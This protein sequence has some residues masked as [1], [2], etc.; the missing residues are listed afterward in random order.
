ML[1]CW[2]KILILTFLARS[3][4]HPRRGPL[5]SF[6]IL[7]LERCHAA[8]HSA[9]SCIAR[10]PLISHGAQSSCPPAKIVFEYCVDLLQPFPLA[11]STG[12]RICT[13]VRHHGRPVS[14][15]QNR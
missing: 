10:S 13:E 6:L 15:F 4:V 5:Y 1:S 11:I 2:T 7:R 9:E 14:K 8:A 12:S 3:I